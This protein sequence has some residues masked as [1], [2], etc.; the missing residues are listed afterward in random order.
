VVTEQEDCVAAAVFGYGHNAL[1]DFIP[2]QIAAAEVDC[3]S[4]CSRPTVWAVT[5]QWIALIAVV[6]VALGITAL[7]F[8]LYW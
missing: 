6:A 4:A 5:E 3:E 8:W 1:V 2:L 7:L